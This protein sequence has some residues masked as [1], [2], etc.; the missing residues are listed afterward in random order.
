[1]A[2]LIGWENAPMVHFGPDVPSNLVIYYKLGTTKAQMDAFEENQL[3]Q[4]RKDNRG[5]DMRFGIQ[6]YLRLAPFEAHGHDAFALDLAPSMTQEQRDA[7]KASLS[8]SSVV[9]AV[10]SDVAPL[11]IPDPDGKGPESTH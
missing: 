11:A 8:N 2:G 5:K 9:F 7:L 4:P 10:Y 3:Y 6:E 1:M